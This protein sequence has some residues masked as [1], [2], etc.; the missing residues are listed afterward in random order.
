MSAPIH[1][2]VPGRLN[3]RTG[4]YIYDRRVVDGLRVLG[5]TVRVHELDGR[6]PLADETASKSLLA[7]AETCA[8][9]D[10]VVIDS[11]C[12]GAARHVVARLAGDGCACVP[13]VHHPASMEAGVRGGTEAGLFRDEQAALDLARRCI[14]TSRSTGVLLHTLFGVDRTRIGVVQPG[15]DPGAPSHRPKT[16]RPVSLLSVGTVSHR[17][18]QITLVRALSQLADLSWSLDCYGSLD[19]EPE[20]AAKVLR[21]TQRLNLDRRIRYHGEVAEARI[22]MAYEDAH[23][24]VMSSRFEGYGMV[25][26]EALAHGLPIVTTDAGPTPDILSEDAAI[27]VSA[28]EPDRLAAALRGVLTDPARYGALQD[29]ARRA[30]AKLEGWEVTVARFAVQLDLAVV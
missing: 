16:G 10:L 28:G 30:A 26:A 11:L 23:L 18:D 19:R 9:P 8:A 20:A 7:V 12:L 4:G 13:L 14:V 3:Q 22:R 25:L 2:L 6:F 27:I 1:L 15:V 29:G 5:R 17:K 21:E 24:F